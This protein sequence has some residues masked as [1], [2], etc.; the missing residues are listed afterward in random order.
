MCR[1]ADQSAPGHDARNDR[2]TAD[3]KNST[4]QEIAH[5]DACNPG[6]SKVAWSRNVSGS[7]MRS[8]VAA[9]GPA[10]DEYPKGIPDVELPFFGR[11]PSDG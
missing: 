2:T 6:L 10:N 8:F 1:K 3:H 7:R 5:A 4:A 11:L 9:I